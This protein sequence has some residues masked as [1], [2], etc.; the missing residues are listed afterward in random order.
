VDRSESLWKQADRKDWFEHQVVEAMRLMDNTEMALSRADAIEVITLPR[1]PADAH[2]NTSMYI[3][4]HVL[5]SE[6][7]SWVGF[8]PPPIKNVNVRGYDP[9]PPSN[10]VSFCDEEYFAGGGAGGGGGGGRRSAAP[11]RAERPLGSQGEAMIVRLTADLESF[12][13]EH[14][15][16]NGQALSEHAAGMMDG[17]MRGDELRRLGQRDA[18]IVLEMVG[19]PVLVLYAG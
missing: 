18:Q 11:Q 9:L 8:L 4:R 2:L 12:M 5:T 16:D 7:T 19:C 6:S 3:C 10:S 13:S 1:E 14:Q 17:L 15:D